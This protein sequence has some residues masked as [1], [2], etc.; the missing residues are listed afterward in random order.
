MTFEL[1]QNPLLT[2]RGPGFPGT[3]QRGDVTIGRNAAY[4]HHSTVVEDT[5]KMESEWDKKETASVKY[6]Y[7]HP[8]S[9]H[10]C[11]LHAA[12]AVSNV[13]FNSFGNERGSLWHVAIF[14]FF[15]VSQPDISCCHNQ[16]HYPSSQ[17]QTCW[18]YNIFSI[19]GHSQLC[20]F[21]VLFRRC[22]LRRLW[23][24]ELPVIHGFR[25]W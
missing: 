13:L 5:K 12:L 11:M 24:N 19:K 22:E 16:N 20:S 21:P 3:S 1:S 8:G 2:G 9:W 15:V 18:E 6:L 25:T 23:G 4:L 14:F 17:L 7:W 10:I